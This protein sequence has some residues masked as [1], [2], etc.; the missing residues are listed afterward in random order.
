MSRLF[1]KRGVAVIGP[2]EGEQACG[3]VGAGRMD[4]PLEILN[5]AMTLVAARRV[6]SWAGAS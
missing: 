1:E 4:E 2:A 5:R 3:E 6:R